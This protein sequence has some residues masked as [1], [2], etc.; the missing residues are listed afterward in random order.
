MAH[1]LALSSVTYAYKAKSYL[2]Q[3]G[4]ESSVVKTPK[5]LSSNGGCG[6]SLKITDDPDQTAN[7]LRA[8]GID[9][10]AVL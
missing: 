3:H 6:Y 10:I 7:L 2:F 1:Y 5:K 4:I 9:V 8:S